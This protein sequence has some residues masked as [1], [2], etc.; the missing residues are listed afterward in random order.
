MSSSDTNPAIAA[1]AYVVAAVGCKLPTFWTKN[2]HAWF[3][4]AEA[5]FRTAH[6][7]VSSTKYDHAFQALPEAVV[8]SVID[9]LE[10]VSSNTTDPYEK[11]KARL[12]WSNQMEKD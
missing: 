10:E 3:L 2:P 8:D 4:R 11:L 1:A 5:Q 9:L 12:L 7:T 6:V